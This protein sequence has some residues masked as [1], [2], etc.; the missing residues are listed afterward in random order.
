MQRSLLIRTL[1]ILLLGC[2]SINTQADQILTGNGDQLTGFISHMDSGQITISTNHSGSVSVQRTNIQSL[3]L[4]RNVRIKLKDGQV[5][6]GKLQS[7][8]D[9]VTLIDTTAGDSLELE[10]LDQVSY[11]YYLS[12]INKEWDV[13]GSIHVAIDLEREEDG[14]ES[15]EWDITLSNSITYKQFR[16]NMLIE[17]ERDKNKDVTTDEELL[18]E[19]SLDYFLD[20]NTFLSAMYR[21]EE[22]DFENL[23]RRRVYGF[24]IGNQPWQA[25]FQKLSYGLDLVH[26]QEEYDEGQNINENGLEFRIYYREETVISNLFFLQD[27]KYLKLESGDQRIDTK[28]ALEYGL[29]Y[30]IGLSLNYKWNY[31]DAPEAGNRK[32]TNNLTFG[33]SYKW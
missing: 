29:P 3:I 14:D 26:L 20:S 2:A 13:S 22:D 16:N 23:H 31:N 19:G 30:N 33:V 10:S 5:I 32:I 7:I 28:S 4:E 25:P 18:F 11:L 6:E 27:H 8:R 9:G 17:F 1:T 21:H 15:E 24:G 12:P